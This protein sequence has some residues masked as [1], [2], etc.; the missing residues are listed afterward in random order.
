M[1][2]EIVDLPMKNGGSF[3]SYVK[4][5]EGIWEYLEIT[6]AF[7]NTLFKKTIMFIAHTLLFSSN[8]TPLGCCFLNDMAGKIPTHC[9]D[10]N[11]LHPLPFVDNLP[12]R[13]KYRFVDK[14]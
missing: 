4:L 1:A 13:L 10:Q 2:I 9:S 8:D 6:P 7:L 14:A 11:L 12:N 5:P 3:H